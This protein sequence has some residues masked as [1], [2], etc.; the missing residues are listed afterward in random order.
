MS[1]VKNLFTLFSK[2]GERNIHWREDL[3]R[4]DVRRQFLGVISG[5]MLAILLLAM[6]GLASCAR[7]DGL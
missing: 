6:A 5:A 2:F 7:S 4:K 1:A 3:A